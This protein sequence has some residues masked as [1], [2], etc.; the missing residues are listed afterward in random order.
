VKVETGFKIGQNLIKLYVVQKSV[1]KFVGLPVY[2]A[3][4]LPNIEMFFM[5]V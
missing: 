4:E 5:H 1:P 3:L 2:A